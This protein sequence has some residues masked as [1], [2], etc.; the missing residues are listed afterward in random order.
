MHPS[1]FAYRVLLLA[2]ALA[3][4]A[5]PALSQNPVT[6]DPATGIS[7]ACAGDAFRTFD[8]WLGSWIVR[9]EAGE[10]VGRNRITPIAQ[11]CAIQ[12]EWTPSR[13]PRGSSINFR[14]PLTG[15]WHQHWVGGGG[16]ILRL[17]GGAVDGAMTLSGT[18][19]T[20]D[21]R[22]ITDRVRWTLLPDGRVEQRWDASTDGGQTWQPAFL[23][24]YEREPPR[25]KRCLASP[26]GLQIR[27]LADSTVLGGSELEIAE[28][29][30]PGSMNLAQGHRHGSTEVL[31]VLEGE[32]D[33]VVDGS[34]QRLQAGMVGVVRTGQQ[35]IHRPL[36]G[37]PVRALVL[38]NPAGE[39]GRIAPAFGACGA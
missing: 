9:N 25:E 33:H 1:P 12:E 27:V 32:L 5:A 21:G 34:S 7:S 26:A 8:Y 39:L 19:S 18:R 30:F 14:D 20:A 13:G 23:G 16:L 38:W 29:T 35:V 2:F 22:S 15:R 17:E 24:F 28:I 37:R 11:G 10:E 3:A 31:Y 4:W 6:V 36:G